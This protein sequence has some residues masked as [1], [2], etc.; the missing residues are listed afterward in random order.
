MAAVVATRLLRGTVL[1]KPKIRLTYNA[2][3]CE[4]SL[5]LLLLE[6]CSSMSFVLEIVT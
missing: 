6:T 4:P 2:K 3:H 1:Q 5:L